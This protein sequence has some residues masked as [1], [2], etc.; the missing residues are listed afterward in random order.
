MER[1]IRNK[2]SITHEIAEILVKNCPANIEIIKTEHKENFTK[3]DE[4]G[5][6]LA[7]IERNI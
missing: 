3:H 7:V 1:L 2:A 6:L 5:A 4:Y